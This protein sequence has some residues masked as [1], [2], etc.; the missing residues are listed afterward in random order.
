MKKF[1]IVFIL[2]LLTQNCYAK[3]KTNPYDAIYNIYQVV[4]SPTE[5]KWTAGGVVDGDKILLTKKDV[6]TMSRYSVY[7]YEDDTVA[8]E[9]SSDFE[10]VKNGIESFVNG[11]HKLTSLKYRL[12]ID[13]FIEVPLT[14]YELQ[15]AFP[16]A[17]IARMSYISKDDKLWVSK[18]IFK[19]KKLIFLND[20]DAFYYK[21]SPRNKKIQNKEIKSLV[22]FNR[23]GIYNF[24]HMGKRDGKV[25]VYVW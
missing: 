7:H 5:N 24:D 20:S 3:N 4:Y 10:F 19:K 15:E 25:I 9:L 11:E 8:F 1:L 17:D 13:G 22:T 6:D 2:L 14:I 18:K 16:D 21:L 23:F 12:V